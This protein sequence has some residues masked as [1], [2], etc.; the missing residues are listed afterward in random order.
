MDAFYQTSTQ[1]A[2]MS[3]KIAQIQ[4]DQGNHRKLFVTV[5]EDKVLTTGESIWRMDDPARLM[6]SVEV[7]GVANSC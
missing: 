6:F 7:V 2:A 1:A 5:P 3:H 4:G